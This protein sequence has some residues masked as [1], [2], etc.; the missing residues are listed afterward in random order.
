MRYYISFILISVFALNSIAHSA[1]LIDSTKIDCTNGIKLE[2]T[3]TTKA[4]HEKSNNGNES[5]EVW[6]YKYSKNTGV[7]FQINNAEFVYLIAPNVAIYRVSIEYSNNPL[8]AVDL[9]NYYA[10]HD[11]FKGVA[12]GVGSVTYKDERGIPHRIPQMKLVKTS[13]KLKPYKK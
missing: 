4:I 8:I 11:I 9:G 2:N 7:C 5:S 10:R 13:M 1:N 6:S 12:K 3:L